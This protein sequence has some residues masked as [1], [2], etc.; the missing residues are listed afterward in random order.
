MGLRLSSGN[1]SAG[2]ELRNKCWKQQEVYF[3]EAEKVPIDP[4]KDEA[5]SLAF[6]KQFRMIGALKLLLH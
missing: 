1:K 6:L 5:R 2:A 3:L 4:W